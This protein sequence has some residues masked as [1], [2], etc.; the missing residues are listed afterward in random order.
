MKS[1]SKEIFVS[2]LAPTG[3]RTYFDSGFDDS[4][5]DHAPGRYSTHAHFA[6]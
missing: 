6:R 3:V 2:I 5:A 1:R 4:V